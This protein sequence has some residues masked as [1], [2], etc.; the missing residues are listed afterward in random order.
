M[1]RGAWQATIR[2]GHKESDTTEQHT[3]SSAIFNLLRKH[4]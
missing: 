1:D 2:E 3:F 4:C